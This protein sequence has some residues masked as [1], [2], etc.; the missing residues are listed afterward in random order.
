MDSSI[1]VITVFTSSAIL[2]ISFTILY[3]PIIVSS[4]FNIL[5]YNLIQSSL[6]LFM[7]WAWFILFSFL[8]MYRF[9][10]AEVVV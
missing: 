3:T 4:P 5:W 10:E 9:G 1:S 2:L 6:S 8:E 7:T